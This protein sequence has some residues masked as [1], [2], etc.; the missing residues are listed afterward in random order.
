MI[1][2]DAGSWEKLSSYIFF[3]FF[4]FFVFYAFRLEKIT[5]AIGERKLL[6]FLEG[7]KQHLY[8]CDM[9]KREETPFPHIIYIII[10]LYY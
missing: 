3:L 2:P 7:D 10:I 4:S 8:H 1:D 9:Q 6:L 5:T